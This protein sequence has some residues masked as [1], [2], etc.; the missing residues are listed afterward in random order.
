MA[1]IRIL[2]SADLPR[3]LDLDDV[4]LSQA[5]VF[6]QLSR[7]SITMPIR[8]V[9]PVGT[10]GNSFVMPAH[11]PSSSDAAVSGSVGVKFIGLRNANPARGL[12]AIQGCV[13]VASE[14]TAEVVGLVDAVN[15]T[16]WRTA[17]GSA[18]A[19][20]L[21]SSPIATTLLVFGSGA[22]ARAHLLFMMLVRPSIK[23]IFIVTTNAT[24]GQ[25]LQQELQSQRSG[26][27]VVVLKDSFETALAEADIICT[28]TSSPTPLFSGH[29][30]KRGA[31]INAI[32]SYQLHTRELDPL[33]VSRC[34]LVAV[35]A[36]DDAREEA[37]DLVDADWDSQV[38]EL[39]SLYSI[40]TGRPHMDVDRSDLGPLAES[41][42]LSKQDT[43][44]GWR[45][46][47]ANES[48]AN[49]DLTLFKSVGVAAQDIAIATVVLR[50][51]AERGVGTVVDM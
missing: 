22:Q 41:L 50:I 30:P 6:A 13:V 23:R 45:T 4:L 36:L 11:V 8:T 3:C 10:K 38:C 51:A 20:M 39:G 35:D 25:L 26:V 16:A 49:K 28:C 42:K 15:L 27:E 33:C 1:P 5:R 34:S 32:G 9:F 48:G 24:T 43:A 14:E 21:L 17:A 44:V 40:D 37:G 47:T 2:R 7:H 29:L 18:L 31:H 12:A 19:T 46:K